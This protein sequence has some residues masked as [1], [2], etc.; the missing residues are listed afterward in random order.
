MAQAY[1]LKLNGITFAQADRPSVAAF[2]ALSYNAEINYEN[3]KSIWNPQKERR[4][5]LQVSQ[6]AIDE[7]TQIIEERTAKFN[8]ES[9]RRFEKKMEEYRKEREAMGIITVEMHHTPGEGFRD[10]TYVIKE[11]A[12]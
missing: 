3:R 9:A 2:I 7:L 1:K 6:A 5:W 12:K 8:R 10:T 11:E 4:G